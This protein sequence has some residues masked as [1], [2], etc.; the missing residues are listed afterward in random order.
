MDMGKLLGWFAI[1]GTVLLVG[2]YVLD[3]VS[4]AQNPLMSF[5]RDL[6]NRSGSRI[7]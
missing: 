7:R 4:F 2:W 3:P 6:S 1:G 5:L